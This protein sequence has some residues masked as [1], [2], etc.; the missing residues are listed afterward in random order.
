MIESELIVSWAERKESIP[1]TLEVDPVLAKA[2]DEG[3]MSI[4]SYVLLLLA[5]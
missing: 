3:E 4:L 1:A 5:S 2:W